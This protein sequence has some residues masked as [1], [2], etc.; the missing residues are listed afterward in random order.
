MSSETI[1]VPVDFAHGA[2]PYQIHVGA[3]LIPGIGALARRA[4]P[5]ARRAVVIADATVA[6]LYGDAVAESLADAGF[7]VDRLEVAPGE[8]S[9]DWPTLIGLI[10][11]LLALRVDRGTL[12]VALGGG[13][14][15]DLV[16]FAAAITLRGLDFVQ[17]PTTLLAQVDSSIGGKTA[18]N[19]KAGKN[20]VGAFHQPVLVVAD[21]ACLDSLPP[22][23]LRAGYAEVI[24]H[25]AISDADF[26]GWL[27][28]HGAAL[29]GGDRPARMAAVEHSC[30][31]KAAVVAA[32]EREAGARALLNFGHTFA[33]ALETATGQGERLVHGEAVA[34]GMVLAYR[35]SERLGLADP[36]HR[37][38][39][40]AHLAAVGL[41]ARLDQIPGDAPAPALLVDLMAG[42]KKTIDGDLV[43]I[44]SRGIGEAEITRGVAPGLVIE[45]LEGAR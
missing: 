19:A 25:A 33:H 5:K 37:H 26:F 21:V 29:V 24:K 15:G 14:I 28:R 17:I 30:R 18:I 27:E 22:R 41:P 38:R 8:G 42:D 2:A 3:G 32:D 43:F 23:E 6:R 20:L 35:L 34:I 9:K 45:V 16:G 1:V 40:E 7:S 31:T 36:A 13:V 4:R 10:D 11:R 44:L 39:L 12:L